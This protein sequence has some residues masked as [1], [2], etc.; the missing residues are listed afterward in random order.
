MPIPCKYPLKQVVA[1]TGRNPTGPPR[2]ALWWITL[3]I[4]HVTDGD[5]GQRQTPTTV[6]CSLA[7]YAV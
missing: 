4:R 2:A 6:S 5:D 3:H 1:L 7:P